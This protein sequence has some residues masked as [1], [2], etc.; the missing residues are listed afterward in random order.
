MVSILA[1]RKLALALEG[2]VEL[3]HFEKASFRIKKKI[4]ATLD[5]KNKRVCLMLNPID[6][7]AFTAFDPNIIYPVPNKWGLKGA[8]YV[9]LSKVKSEVLQDAL[10]VSYQ[11]II[12]KK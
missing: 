11:T 9:E 5:E 12:S 8:T 3:P 2:A 10:S 4:F 6:Q 7:S 1:F